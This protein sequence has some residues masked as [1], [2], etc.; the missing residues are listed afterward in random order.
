MHAEKIEAIFLIYSGDNNA[1][2]FYILR[3]GKSVA[4][5][6]LLSQFAK[7]VY[8]SKVCDVEMKKEFA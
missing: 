5:C 4:L 1:I 2:H 3:Y 8:S 6:N 7:L